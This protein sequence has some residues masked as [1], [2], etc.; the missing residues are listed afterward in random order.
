MIA[1][2]VMLVLMLVIIS[3]YTGLVILEHGLTLFS[4]FF[5]EIASSTWSGQ[6]NLDFFMMLVLS[7]LWVAWRHGFTF[8]GVV[9]GLLATV[10]GILFLSCYLLIMISR[11]ATDPRS[12]LLGDRES[13]SKTSD[14]T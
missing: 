10:G 2:R 6:F 8:N 7:G 1:F 4:V 11:G 12:L 9:L 5:L 3:G 14:K 13:L